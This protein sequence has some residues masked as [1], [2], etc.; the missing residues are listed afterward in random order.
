VATTAREN[1]SYGSFFTA[2]TCQRGDVLYICIPAHN[3][4]PT[5]GVLL[6]RIR[7]VFQE[8][9]REYEVIVYDDA[10]TDA[11]PETLAPYAEVMPL[12]LLRGEQQLGYAG[13]LERLCRAAVKRTRYPRRDAFVVMQADF[14]D[15]PEHLPELVKRFEGGADVVVAERGELRDAPLPV[16]RLRRV[17]PWVL[18]PFVRVAG[19]RDPLNALRLVRLSVLRDLLRA[20]GDAPIVT[21][22]GWAANVELLLRCVPFARRVETVEIEPRYGLRPRETRVRPLADALA[23]FHFARHAR[24]L[25][26]RPPGPPAVSGAASPPPTPAAS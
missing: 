4:A 12:T 15:L 17:A 9:S 18:R 1:L 21:A 22:P 3:E 24:G 26:P 20:Q 25:R 14:T 7:K 11:T 8:Y 19:V 13:A 23:L 2:W 16:Q 10:S 5:V 6:W